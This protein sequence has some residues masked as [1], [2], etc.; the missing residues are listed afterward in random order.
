[1]HRYF[2]KFGSNE[3]FINLGAVHDGLNKIFITDVNN[4][5]L[6]LIVLSEGIC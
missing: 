4:S 5:G 6:L 3:I 1:M 2:L